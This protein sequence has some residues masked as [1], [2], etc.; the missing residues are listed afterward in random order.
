[1]VVSNDSSYQ[2]VKVTVDVRQEDLDYIEG[3]YY[4]EPASPKRMVEWFFEL[5]LKESRSRDK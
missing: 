2:T 4:G 5:Q 1:M 3:K